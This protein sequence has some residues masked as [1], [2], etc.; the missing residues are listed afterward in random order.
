MKTLS[1]SSERAAMAGVVLLAGL[2]RF[3]AIDAKTIWLDEAF[4]IWVA[5]LPLPKLLR[6]VASVDHHPPLY[7]LLQHG[8]Q[9]AL[10]NSAFAVRSLPALLGVATVPLLYAAGR[11]LTDGTTA[12]M[13]ALL[14]AV[15][16]FHVRYGQESRMYALMTLLAA[17]ALLCLAVWLA[18]SRAGSVQRRAAMGGLAV[19][20]A[21]LML[22]HNTAALLFPAALNAGVAGAFWMQGASAKTAGVGGTLGD[23]GFVL[24]WL[25]VQ[26]AALLLWLPWGPAFWA[27][28]QTVYHEFWIQQPSGYSVWL[29]FH[30]F[31]L[32][33]PE[34]WFPAAPWWDL[35]YWGLT[36]GG[37]WALRRRR[38]VAVL[39]AAMFIVPPVLELLA[40]LRRPVFSDRTLIWTTLPYYLF[41]AA[42]LRGLAEGAKATRWRTVAAS[43]VAVL[44]V[45]L[46]V[47][48]LHAYFTGYEKEDWR[49][50]AACV[51]EGARPGDLAVFHAPWVQIPFAYYYRGQGAPVEMR[52]APADLFAT[53]E[54]EPAMRTEDLPA[55][56]NL[57]A[58][59]ERVWLVYSHEWYSDAGGL[60]PQEIER[61]M[62]AA[63]ECTFLG[64]RV[65]RFERR[66]G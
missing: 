8:W 40:G 38:P 33:F 50:A 16:P 5:E 20:Q 1:K 48:S 7:Y 39:L 61:V 28:A 30:N 64:G 62:V 12:L 26:A 53:G 9:V 58:G 13:A 65:I 21:L 19:T 32:A 59:R 22:T 52:G 37:V 63:D 6:F 14:L 18:D 60:V 45:G 42:G 54:L 31:N 29:A 41:V 49:S 44:L 46:T 27:Q 57:I 51:A 23:K 55:L 2:L 17:G 10:G 25:A 36:L 56:R 47:Y 34:G 11:R 3:W 35:L 4:S 66:G 43:A 15:S 24:R